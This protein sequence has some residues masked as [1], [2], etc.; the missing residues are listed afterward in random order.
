MARFKV[1]K[2]KTWH[3]KE[4]F[5]KECWIRLDTGIYLRSGVYS[6]YVG[7]VKEDLNGESKYIVEKAFRTLPLAL[8]YMI[9]MALR[10]SES[11]SFADLVKETNE[12]NSK[13]KEWK[14]QIL[15]RDNE[16]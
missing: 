8:Q 14:K 6:W 11:Q 1:P 10:V 9:D 7:K 13:L 5:D 12:I 2:N 16:V 4:E 3:T 15:D